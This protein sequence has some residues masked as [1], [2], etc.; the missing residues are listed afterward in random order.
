MSMLEEIIEEKDDLPCTLMLAVIASDAETKIK[1]LSIPVQG[2]KAV[3]N[4][5]LQ[6]ARCGL[7]QCTIDI[8]SEYETAIVAWLYSGGY[9]AAGNGKGVINI[10]W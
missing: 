5:L 2:K 7:R 1:A 4:A 9:G 8:P 6:A 3:K 10:V